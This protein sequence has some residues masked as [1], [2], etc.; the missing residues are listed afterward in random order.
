MKCLCECGC[1][2]LTS[3][4]ISRRT[5]MPVR[6]I[7]GHEGRSNIAISNK[8]RESRKKHCECGCG[9]LTSGKMS[10]HEKG[11]C[12]SYVKGHESRINNGHPWNYKLKG[13]RSGPN[14]H[15]WKGGIV[16]SN[17]KK[18]IRY[19]F[20]Y[21]MWRRNI[22]TRDNYTC[23]ECGIRGTTLNADHKK[24]FAIIIDENNIKTVDQALACVE[25]WD[26][27]NGKTLCEAC[28]KKTPS[29]MN[30]WYKPAVQS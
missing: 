15:L 5:K 4:G 24:P 26:L 29:Y 18:S 27:N 1:G 17:F 21:R 7:K 14:S 20:E 16:I 11:K 8:K 3:G 2:N 25:L 6:F 23:Q 22:F 10:H 19:L 13:F 9:Q 12:V 28:H 30:R